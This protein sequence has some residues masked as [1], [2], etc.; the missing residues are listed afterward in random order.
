MNNI[1]DG[2]RTDG[3]SL[4]RK[5]IN[6]RPLQKIDVCKYTIYMINNG[7]SFQ[8]NTSL[9]NR[10]HNDHSLVYKEVMRQ[11]SV[12]VEVQDRKLLALAANSDVSRAD[13]RNMYYLKTGHM[14][15]YNQVSYI[16]DFTTYL[17][18]GKKKT[19]GDASNNV[20]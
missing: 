19:D 15:L 13:S 11:P 1:K 14:R 2:R 16:C 3:K 4:P 18:F 17:L 12:L 7:F 6:V 10:D 5:C 20:I 8:L 9:G